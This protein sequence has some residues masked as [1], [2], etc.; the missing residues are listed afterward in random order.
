VTRLAVLTDD[1]TGPVVRHRVLAVLPCL[2]EAGFDDVRIVPVE[3]GL[4]ARRAAF[5]EAGE[6]RNVLLVRR[7]FTRFDFG[8]LRAAAG[9]LA[10]DF[11]D[12]LCF[13]DP[14]RGRPESHVRARRFARTVKGA[15]LVLAGNPYL[16][17]LAREHGA[18]A[19]VV[20]APTP[21]DT[22]RY[23]PGPET[24]RRGFRVGWIGSRSTRPYLRLVA[25]PLR[26]LVR[27]RDDV[28]VAVMADAPPHELDG[29][30]VEFTPWSEEAEV[31]F[32]RSLHAGLM[33]LTDD[34]WSRGKCGFKLLQ[35]M[36]CGVPAV[37]SPVGVN[38]AI[39]EG[40]A[41]ARLA[42][43]DAEWVA[44]LEEFAADPDV[45]AALAARARAEAEAKWSSR[46]LGPRL[47]SS[48]AAWAAA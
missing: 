21:V 7:L 17:G 44:A 2:R 31:P 32:L 15:D 30:P 6:R 24:P 40:G 36:A 25:A 10:Y 28:V 39:A 14:T 20:V 4:R 23:A 5:R 43:T 22:D 41:T 42:A 46:A 33:P 1:P 11:D 18:V 8:A 34:V 48:L 37:A 47:A 45:A 13:R 27:R 29:L 35:Y 26:E 12:A 38:V 9:R 16:G 19:P 3:K